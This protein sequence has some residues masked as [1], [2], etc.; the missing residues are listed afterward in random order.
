M[1]HDCVESVGLQPRMLALE[2]HANLLTFCVRRR[3]I[4]GSCV[5]S[6]WLMSHLDVAD[7]DATCCSGAQHSFG[8]LLSY[9]R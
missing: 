9:T 4:R 7:I 1:I 6:T 5:D 8:D 3:E 2:V